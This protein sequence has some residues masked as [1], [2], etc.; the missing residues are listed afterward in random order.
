MFPIFWL[1]PYRFLLLP[2]N[3]DYALQTES[4][5]MLRDKKCQLSTLNKT[6]FLFPLSHF[7]KLVYFSRWK[8]CRFL[9]LIGHQTN[10]HCCYD[11]LIYIN[12]NAMNGM[13]KRKKSKCSFIICGIMKMPIFTKCWKCVANHQMKGKRW[14]QNESNAQQPLKARQRMR[15]CEFPIQFICVTMLILLYEKRKCSFGMIFF[16]DDVHWN[17]FAVL[18]PAS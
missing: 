1:V 18:I 11:F 14:Y 6:P 10:H 12:L 2:L 9:L 13:I 17:T 4:S 16:I 5:E 15:N 3:R 7:I 8:K